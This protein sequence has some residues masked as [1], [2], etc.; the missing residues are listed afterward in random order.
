MVHLPQNGTIGCIFPVGFKGNR[1]HYWKYMVKE[2]NK[3]TSRGLNQMEVLFFSESAEIQCLSWR[4]LSR[5]VGLPL[6]GCGVG[7][8]SLELVCRETNFRCALVECTFWDCFEGYSFI[9]PYEDFRL[10]CRCKQAQFYHG[11]VIPFT[12][13]NIFLP[14]TFTPTPFKGT[15]GIQE[16]TRRPLAGSALLAHLRNSSGVLSQRSLPP[17]CCR[18]L[19]H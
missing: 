1:F 17:C 11:L 18:R 12:D 14:C 2:N 19:Y 3:H 6:D 7:G 13:V 5:S 9:G 8:S 15:R 10:T 16:Y 4:R